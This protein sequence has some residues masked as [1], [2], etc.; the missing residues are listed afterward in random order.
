MAYINGK[1]ILFSAALG[2]GDSGVAVNGIVEQYKVNAGA[3][4]NAGDFV[5]FI[6]KTQADEISASATYRIVAERISNNAVAVLYKGL[7]AYHITVLSFNGTSVSTETVYTLPTAAYTAMDVYNDNEIFVTYAVDADGIYST[8]LYFDGST[9]VEKIGA[10]YV[11]NAYTFSSITCDKLAD[12]TVVLF[13]TDDSATSTSYKTTICRHIVTI[14]DGTMTYGDKVTIKKGSYSNGTLSG[15]HTSNSAK[16]I[17]QRIGENKVAMTYYNT[18]YSWSNYSGSRYSY[19]YSTFFYVVQ[20]DD[21]VVGALE[22]IAQSSTESDSYAQRALICPID[23]NTT[24]L[25]TSSKVIILSISGTK[26]TVLATQDIATTMLGS[27]NN[28]PKTQACRL[29]ENRIAI[30]SGA[31]FRVFQYEDG[32][33]ILV[34]TVTVPIDGTTNALHIVPSSETSGVL[35]REGSTGAFISYEITADGVIFQENTNTTNGTYIQPATS[36]LYNVGV[37]VGYGAEGQ[38][39]GVYCVGNE[40]AASGNA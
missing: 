9:L 37:A 4:V 26:A 18:V 39:I 12:G 3:T 15:G 24:A 21:G 8:L 33:L 23:E 29:S 17:S 14:A 1:E 34:H 13:Y 27:S 28:T 22:N 5:E 40:A 31:E 35:F 19:T 2:S 30:C 7:S 25:V 32:A 11:A 36:R 20:Y 38:T 6:M 10:T 16:I